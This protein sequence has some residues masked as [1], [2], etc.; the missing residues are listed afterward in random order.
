MSPF[1]FV[2]PPLIPPYIYTSGFSIQ[3]N[4]L[5]SYMIPTKKTSAPLVEL[6]YA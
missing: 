1:Q 2:I 4:I 3:N 6:Q 5:E